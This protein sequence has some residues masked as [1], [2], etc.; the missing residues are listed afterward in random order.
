MV[1]NEK[2][3]SSCLSYEAIVYYSGLTKLIVKTCCLSVSLSSCVFVGA[4]AFM[5][6]V[7]FVAVLSSGH[8][9]AISLSF[10]HVAAHDSG[11]SCWA[12][13]LTTSPERIRYPGI[14]VRT[15]EFCQR[16]C[17]GEYSVTDPH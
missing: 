2:V 9:R 6:L 4:S 17:P 16:E 11:I 10:Q 3:P 7:V 1:R 12:C 14:S 13:G 5:R 8:L 15:S